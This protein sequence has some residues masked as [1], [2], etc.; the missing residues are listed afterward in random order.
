M[1]VQLRLLGNRQFYNLVY[2]PAFLLCLVLIVF[3]GIAEC[4]QS[5]KN[6]DSMLHA[7]SISEKL[8]SNLQHNETEL[9]TE[10]HRFDPKFLSEMELKEISVEAP[11]S[12]FIIKRKYSKE[13]LLSNYFEN[14]GA[15]HGPSFLLRPAGQSSSPAP[16][17]KAVI[18]GHKYHSNKP[19]IALP[20]LTS[21]SI[22]KL[23]PYLIDVKAFEFIKVSDDGLITIRPRFPASLPDTNYFPIIKDSWRKRIFNWEQFQKGSLTK[24]ESSSD[25]FS[26][27]IVYGFKITL[28]YTEDKLSDLE[29]RSEPAEFYTCMSFSGMEFNTYDSIMHLLSDD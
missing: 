20:Q 8:N 4:G 6:P 15:D 29:Q 9:S 11:S 18:N 21:S 13:D 17:F 12:E 28:S 3:A 1:T 19:G 23:E 25:Q 5:N 10:R 24:F 16:E 27:P 7:I 26:C 22:R 2:K 14:N